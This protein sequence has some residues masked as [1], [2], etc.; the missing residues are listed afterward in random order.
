MKILK[1]KPEGPFQLGL[2]RVAPTKKDGKKK[3]CSAINEGV[4]QKYTVNI[5]KHI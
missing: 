3:G 4:I 1:K 5:H 2:S